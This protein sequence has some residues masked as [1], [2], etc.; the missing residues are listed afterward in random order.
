[1]PAG[2]TGTSHRVQTAVG[3]V[4]VVVG[5]EQPERVGPDINCT[6]THSFAGPGHRRKS[7]MSL[8]RRW[9]AGVSSAWACSDGTTRSSFT[10]SGAGF[11]RG[12]RRPGDL[13]EP[14]VPWLRI[15]GSSI[16]T[17]GTG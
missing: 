12:R 11:D 13:V 1:Q 9:K 6:E 3:P 7:S 10:G 4:L 16:V 8:E 17:G 2:L 5:H 15:V 14:G